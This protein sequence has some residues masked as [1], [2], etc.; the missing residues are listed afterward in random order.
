MREIAGAPAD[1]RRRPAD[2]PQRASGSACGSRRRRAAGRRCPWRVRPGRPTPGSWIRRPRRPADRGETAGVH[3]GVDRAQPGPVGAA[4]LLPAPGMGVARGD[5]R[6]LGVGLGGQAPWKAASRARTGSGKRGGGAREVVL[7]QPH[8][9]L[10]DQQWGAEEAFGEQPGKGGGRR[11]T[12]RGTVPPRR[13]PGRGVIAAVVAAVVAVP[14]ERERAQGDLQPLGD[15]QQVRDPCAPRGGQ[16]AG[17]AAG[18]LQE[19]HGLLGAEQCGESAVLTG[20]LGEPVQ[21]GGETVRLPVRASVAG[22]AP[23]VAAGVCAG[24]KAAARSP[25]CSAKA[26]RSRRPVAAPA[27]PHRD[28]RCSWGS[29][30]SGAI[31]TCRTCGG[32]SHPA[33]ASPG[34]RSVLSA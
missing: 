10:G 26:R 8:A 29:P 6:R 20:E 13:V 2:D 17:S 9:V 5:Q 1:R 7:P 11:R 31:R 12:W 16:P 30:H 23:P 28:A 33:A 22:C 27:D 4:S 14:V 24:R 18:A 32:S 15:G 25:K 3:A 34:G 19:A 21:T